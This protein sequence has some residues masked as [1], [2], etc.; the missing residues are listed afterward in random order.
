MCNMVMDIQLISRCKVAIS[1]CAK[2]YI[3][4]VLGALHDMEYAQCT[5]H[6]ALCTMLCEVYSV[7]AFCSLL[8]PQFTTPPAWARYRPIALKPYED[9]FDDYQDCS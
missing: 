4:F 6:N 1:E 2:C 8:V 5:M 3:N 7:R 9:A